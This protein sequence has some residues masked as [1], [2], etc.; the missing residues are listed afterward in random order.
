MGRDL[1][2]DLGTANTIVYRLG[3]GIVFDEPTVVA[4]HASTGSVVAIGEAA[5][6]LIGGDSGNVVAMRPLR[7][8]TVTE[9]EMTQRYLGSVIR[10][11][12][13]GRFPKPRVLICI[14]SESS[15]V[16]KRAVVEAVTSSGG[17]HVTLGE[18]ALA[19]AIG[20]GLRR[21]LGGAPPEGTHDVAETGMFLTGGG[22][23]L[24]GLDQLLA[25]DCEVPVRVAEKPLETV[26]IG[27]GHMLEHLE[28]YRSAFQ[29][30]RPAGRS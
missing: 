26:A 13:P 8:G 2:I 23:L 9:F 14:P 1:A 16:E 11:V 20:A 12:A 22:S 21:T 18:E 7:E 17:K 24:N 3:E 4:L 19:A 5:W 15:E 30:V 25:Q 10:R 6:D 28:E 27:A 29:L